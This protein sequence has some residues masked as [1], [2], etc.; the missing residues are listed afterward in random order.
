MQYYF[1]YLVIFYPVSIILCTI[2][3]NNV[4]PQYK[5]YKAQKIQPSLFPEYDVTKLEYLTSIITMVTSYIIMILLTY[6]EGRVIAC[7]LRAFGI[8]N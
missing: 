2:L 5:E 1:L 6:F 7:I 8:L 4:I 3:I